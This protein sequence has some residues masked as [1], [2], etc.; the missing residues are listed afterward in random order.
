MS[1]IS[2]QMLFTGSN[3]KYRCIYHGKHSNSKQIPI[4]CD[5]VF[6]NS[7]FLPLGVPFCVSLKL[8]LLCHSIRHNQ[9]HVQKV[10]S[11]R[12]SIP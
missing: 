9:D 12:P 5:Q 8:F 7:E 3:E 6:Q 11:C 2:N 4:Q 1:E 10:D